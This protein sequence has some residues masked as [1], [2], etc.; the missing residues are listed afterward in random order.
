MG[1]LVLVLP[2]PTRAKIKNPNTGATLVSLRE[3]FMAPPPF[4]NC[5]LQ[6][7]RQTQALA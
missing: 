4:G 3:E 6:I 2:Q 5:E 7:S 1:G